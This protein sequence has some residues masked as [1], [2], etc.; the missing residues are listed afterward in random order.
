MIKT[1][2]QFLIPWW[3][4]EPVKPPPP[5]IPYEDFQDGI[6]LKENELGTEFR[7]IAE[8]LNAGHELNDDDYAAAKNIISTLQK[9]VE[10]RVHEQNIEMWRKSIEDL[11]K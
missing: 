4:F 10:R 5:P 9:G 8:K 1:I 6:E 7:K 3:T 2:L 11:S